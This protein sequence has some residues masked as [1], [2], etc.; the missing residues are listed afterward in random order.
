MNLA[1]QNRFL[2]A[3]RSGNLKEL[4]ACVQQVEDETNIQQTEEA[5]SNQLQETGSSLKTEDKNIQNDSVQND[6]DS[7]AKPKTDRKNRLD[8]D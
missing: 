2:T 8:I 5:S 4:D 7:K 3:V 6:Q 1:L